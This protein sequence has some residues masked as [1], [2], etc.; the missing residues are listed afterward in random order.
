MSKLIKRNKKIIRNTIKNL[1]PGD[2]I[3]GIYNSPYKVTNYN[4]VCKVIYVNKK[5]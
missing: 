4:C 3:R 2:F 5:H 1:K